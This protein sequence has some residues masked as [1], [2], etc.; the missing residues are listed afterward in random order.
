[1]SWK[2]ATWIKG[3]KTITGCWVYS[4]S[5]RTFVVELDDKDEVTGGRRRIETGDDSLNFNG[6]KLKDE[7]L[8]VRFAKCK[9]PGVA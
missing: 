2:K 1:M 5:R 8:E 7:P 4:W 3:D 6:W 9:S